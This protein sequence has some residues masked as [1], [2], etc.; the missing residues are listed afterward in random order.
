MRIPLFL[1]LLF[2]AIF[3]VAAAFLAF[4]MT[5]SKT[6]GP[7]FY[8]SVL[9]IF[10]DGS[11]EVGAYRFSSGD[12]RV[13]TGDFNASS[14]DGNSGKRMVKSGLESKK[15]PGLPEGFFAQ[16]FCSDGSGT[17][18][19]GG[20]TGTKYGFAKIFRLNGTDSAVSIAE[21]S[22]FRFRNCAFGNIG[23]PV[24]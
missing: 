22:E 24:F 11:E 5:G 3:L 9:R 20:K 15:V 17:Y 14:N 21:S 18:V 4:G 8:A 2:S 16:G 7:A 13:F 6:G 19:A 1:R 10:P 23:G 12:F